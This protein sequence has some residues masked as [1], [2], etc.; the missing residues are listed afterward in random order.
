MRELQYCEILKTNINVINMQDALAYIEAQI[1]VLR[2]RY[3]CVSN[4]HTTVMAYE[5]EAYRT[6][7]NSAAMALPDGGPL[8]KYSRSAGFEHAERVTGPDLM[9]ELFRRSG[10]KGYRHYFYGST[11]ET[12]DD[13]RAALERD[14][15]DMVIAGMYAPP[16]RALTESED[17]EIIAQI[18]DA[19]P[20]F[21]WVG[22][23]APKQE[24]W[25][26]SHRDKLNAVSVGVG[27]G[28]DYL[29]GHIRRAPRIMQALCMEW[30][31]RLL[32]DPKRLWKRYVTTNAKFIKYLMRERKTGSHEK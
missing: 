23:G 2:G 10:A 22:L 27:A 11:Q 29:A 31:Y 14:Y 30:L 25:M 1:D 26:Y 24:E 12:L 28:F 13:M 18:N 17:K 9:V 32:Q 21:I 8:S 7:Q 20:D 16:F 3:I 19:R 5:N 4:V 6:I 15:P